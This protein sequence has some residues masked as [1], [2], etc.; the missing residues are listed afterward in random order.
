MC[1]VFNACF[2]EQGAGG[3][4]RGAGGGGRGAGPGAGEG[5]LSTSFLALYN[6]VQ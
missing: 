4:G 5:G 3:G 1:D 6:M 2:K